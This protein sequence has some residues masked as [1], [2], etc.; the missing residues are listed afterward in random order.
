MWVTSSG[1]Y[2]HYA[3]PLA[4]RSNSTTSSTARVLPARRVS[5]QTM[6]SVGV[7]SVAIRSVNTPPPFLQSARLTPN[8]DTVPDSVRSWDRAD[9]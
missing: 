9:M 6:N 8:I 4:Q 5:T 7:S 1:L 3:I 2:Q